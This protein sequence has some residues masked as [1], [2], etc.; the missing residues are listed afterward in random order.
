[1]AAFRVVRS[2]LP[3][4]LGQIPDRGSQR[5]R[6]TDGMLGWGAETARAAIASRGER[7]P[8]FPPCTSREVAK[9][10]LDGVT[11]GACFDAERIS[12]V[13]VRTKSRRR[14]SRIMPST[15]VPE[16]SCGSSHGR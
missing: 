13:L 2:V 4:T 5:S 8:T 11:P 12:Q 7:Q 10:A 16:K 9:A 3:R 14:A 15:V 6:E 1:M